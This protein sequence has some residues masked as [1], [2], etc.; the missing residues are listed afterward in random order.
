MSKELTNSEKGLPANS[1]RE[2]LVEIEE[3]IKDYRSVFPEPLGLA[4]N[5]SLAKQASNEIVTLRNAIAIA[6]EIIAGGGTEENFVSVL[7]E[8]LNE[9]R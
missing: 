9:I 4:P 2:L 8:A 7:E 5:L 1:C 6:L 3:S